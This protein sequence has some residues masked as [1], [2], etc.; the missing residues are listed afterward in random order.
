M[1]WKASRFCTRFYVRDNCGYT[2]IHIY[3]NVHIASYLTYIDI[4]CTYA[5]KSVQ[6][7]QQLNIIVE[8]TPFFSL[9]LSTALS[10]KFRLFRI[11]RGSFLLDIIS[12]SANKK[13]ACSRKGARKMKRLVSVRNNNVLSR[14]AGWTATLQIIIT[15]IYIYIYTRSAST[16]MFRV[17]DWTRITEYYLIIFLCV[18]KII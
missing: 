13:K 2:H 5:Q 8:C 12:R 1:L 14:C 9:S 17:N 11:P 16:R 3:I 4:R 7:R 6:W 10:R 18:R 15:Y